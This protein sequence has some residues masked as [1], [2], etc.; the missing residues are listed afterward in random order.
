MKPVALNSIAGAAASSNVKS[1][2]S[3]ES[4]K[5][6]M[7][8]FVGSKDDLKTEM[9]KYLPDISQEE[10]GKFVDDFFPKEEQEQQE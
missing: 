6:T 9:K 3:D 4:I 5:T 7:A 2:T 10:I 1:E 8:Q